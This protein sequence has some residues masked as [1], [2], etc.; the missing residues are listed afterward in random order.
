M[1]VGSCISTLVSSTKS[2]GEEVLAVL[3]TWGA[4]RMLRSTMGLLEVNDGSRHP[5][6]PRRPSTRTWARDCRAPIAVVVRRSQRNRS[7]PGTDTTSALSGALALYHPARGTEA[8]L[9]ETERRERR[10]DIP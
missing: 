3:L 6:P 5:R 2:L 9:S 4:R 10:G 8:R 1:L 7:Q